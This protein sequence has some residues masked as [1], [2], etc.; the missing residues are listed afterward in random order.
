MRALGLDIGSVR[1]GV[2]VSDPDGRIASPVAVLDARDM[3]RAMRV[4]R[5]YVEDYEIERLVVG[6]PLTLG[7]E[8][9]PQAVE[10]RTTGELLSRELDV[11]LEYHD[12][13]H[14][15]TEARRSMREAGL[16]ER[17]QRGSLDKV[18]A[19]IVLQGW[20]DARRVAAL[21]GMDDR[22]E[23]NITSG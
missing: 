16:S 15:S 9:G 10:V 21:G 5:E 8:E 7:G 14:S 23:P 22:R 11:P 3:P 4:L 20:L 2:A 12:E 17:E 13:R 19:A 1:I 18:A 6:L